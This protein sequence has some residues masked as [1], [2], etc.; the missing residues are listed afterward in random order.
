MTILAAI[1][2]VAVGWLLPQP[3]WFTVLIAT[4]KT[5]WAERKSK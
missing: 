1:I 3:I 5:W 4:V 2:G